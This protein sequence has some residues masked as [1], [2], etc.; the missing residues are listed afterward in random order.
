MPIE[1]NEPREEVYD[2]PGSRREQAF[3]QLAKGLANNTI[4]RGDALKWAGRALAGALVASIPGIAWAQN[5][6]QDPS[7]KGGAGADQYSPQAALSLGDDLLLRRLHRHKHQYIQ[8]RRLRQCLHSREA[9]PER[10]VCVP[11]GVD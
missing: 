4:S 2:Q 8:L 3:D 1:N 6:P 7:G 5:S 11:I 9:V 10:G